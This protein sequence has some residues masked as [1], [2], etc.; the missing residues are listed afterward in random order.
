MNETAILESQREVEDT[1]SGAC[2]GILRRNVGEGDAAQLELMLL[3][4]YFDKLSAE[5]DPEAALLGIVNGEFYKSFFRLGK[6]VEEL[7]DDYSTD[8][9]HASVRMQ[10]DAMKVQLGRLI[11]RLAQVRLA[12]NNAPK[13]TARLG[14]R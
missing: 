14:R 11:G 5:E 10:G 4:R 12:L 3:N 8:V 6:V 9:E 1:A 7:S 2:N 13:P